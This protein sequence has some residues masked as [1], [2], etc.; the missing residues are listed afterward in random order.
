MHVA[1]MQSLTLYRREKT[2]AADALTLGVAKSTKHLPTSS[3]S[4]ET[5]ELVCVDCWCEV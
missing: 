2:Y 3:L 5:E 4:G 1:S